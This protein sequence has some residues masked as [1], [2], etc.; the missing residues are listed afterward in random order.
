MFRA[1]VLT[2][3]L[4]LAAI[5]VPNIAAADAPNEYEVK[6]LMLFNLTHF[7][8]WPASAFG[9]DKSPIV[10]GVLGRDPFG[11]YL[12]ECRPGR[13][14]QRADGSSSKN[15]TR[16]QAL[17]A[18]SYPVYLKANEKPKLSR[19]YFQSSQRPPGPHRIRDRKS[20]RLSPQWHASYL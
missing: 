5:C 13:D 3:A 2:I 12:A 4:A 15:F 10:I 18:V 14:R 7:V 16:A 20:F 17:G 9:D 19:K 8:D 6:A 11:H 1:F